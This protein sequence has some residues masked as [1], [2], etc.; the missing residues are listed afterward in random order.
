MTALRDKVAVITGATSGIGLAIAKRLHGAGARVVITGR[1]ADKLAATA[2]QLDGAPHV[3]G[4]VC[5]PQ[6][7]QALMDLAVSE[8]GRCD[9]VVNNA[10]VIHNGPID[11][12]DIE[13]VCEMVR[14]NVEAAFRVAYTA[15]KQFDKAGSGHLLNIS[16]VLGT[17]VRLFTGAYAGTKYAIEAL[18]EAL[19]IELARRPIHVT[20]IQPGLVMTELHR[21]FP[22]HPKE[23]MQVERPLVPEDVADAVMFTLTRPAHVTIPTMLVLPKDH[24]T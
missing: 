7:A 4:D 2:A 1:N 9:I 13:K 12:I 17:K 14:I 8:Y 5:E 21:D 23:P 6:L 11:K 22:V 3:A 24:K 16:S 10:G 15:V 19:R 18:S 20:C